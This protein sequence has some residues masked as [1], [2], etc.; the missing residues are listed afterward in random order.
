MANKFTL[1]IEDTEIKILITRGNTVEKWASLLLE[2]SLV[3]DGVILDEDQVAAGIKMLLQ[4]S[5]VN[6]RKVTVGLSGLNSIFRVISLPELPQ[7]MLPEAVENEAGRVIPVPLEQVYLSYQQL[8]SAK[9]ETRLFLVAYPRNSTDTLIK[10][11]E[12]AG[13]KPNVMDLAPL[14]LARCANAP[15]AIIVN[16][17]LTY[18]DIVIMVE[19]MPRLIRS[20][21]LPVDVSSMEGKLPT[22]AEELSRT[23]AFY[24]SSYPGEPVD[25][26]VPVLVC[27]DLSESPDSWETLVGKAG[28]PVSELTSPV[29]LVE[30]FRPGQYMVNIGLALKGWPAKGEQDYSSIVDFNALPEVYRPAVFKLNRVITP[31]AIVVAVGALAYGGLLIRNAMSETSQ[32]ESQ[33]TQVQAQAD[34][35]RSEMISINQAIDEQNAALDPLPGQVTQMEDELSSMQATNDALNSQLTSL[36]K[37]LEKINGDLR[38]AINLLPDNVTLLGI[39]CVGDGVTLNGSAANENDIY[40]YAKA[41]RSGGRFSE[42]VVSSITSKSITQASGEETIVSNFTFLLK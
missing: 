24:N 3:R 13:L 20:L 4:L 19:R 18:L 5:G 26:S 21:S 11:V 31:V 39:Q 9:G 42:V 14:A 8:T 10:T 38:E 33:V 15:R 25:S 2:P 7:T 34:T 28:Y 17:W 40:A 6:E 16:S 1:Y 32:L 12:K 35:L 36:D 37:G 41:L 23:V 30:T 29:Q 22:I 27:G